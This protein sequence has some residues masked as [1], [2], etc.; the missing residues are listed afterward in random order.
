MAKAAKPD[1]VKLG[2]QPQPHEPV[3]LRQ[4]VC[5]EHGKLFID[6]LGPAWT[7]VNTIGTGANGR[8]AATRPGLPGT[9]VVGQA[10][11]RENGPLYPLGWHL[12]PAARAAMA[13]Q[14][15]D[16]DTDALLGGVHADRG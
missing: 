8:L 15:K 4:P 5:A 12:S 14:A 11:L 3:G 7:A 13:E 9:A 10:E 16:L 6:L 2:G 1:L